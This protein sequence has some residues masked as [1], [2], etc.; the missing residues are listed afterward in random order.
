MVDRAHAAQARRSNSGIVLAAKSPVDVGESALLARAASFS[1]CRSLADLT[2]DKLREISGREGLDF[3]TSL[4]YDRVKRSE[5]HAAFIDRIDQWQTSD[6][7]IGAGNVVVGVIPAAFYKET[8]NSGADGKLI[9]EEGRHLGLQSKL[10]PLSSTGTLAE[11]SKIIF[12]WLANHQGNEIILVSLCKGSADVKFAL[13]SPGAQEK[14][15]D[16]S[17][18]VNICGT[19]N[20]SP[21]AEWLLAAKPRYF[22][23]WVCC[24]C[25]GYGM[26]FLREVAPSRQGPLTQPLKLPSSIRLI[27]V[28]GFP[29][30][31]HLTNQ[32][33]RICYERV[34]PQGP[35]DGGVLLADACQL[36]GVIYPVWGADHY[37]R[38][39]S[40]A[41]QIIGAIL[42]SLMADSN[43]AAPGSANE[44]PANG[45]TAQTFSESRH[46]NNTKG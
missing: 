23:T 19:L 15:R 38:P 14:F 12:D 5:Q 21:V 35:N 4:L 37:L 29:L 10:I 9:L 11:N 45:Q 13:N 30:R 6:R 20:G 27:N 25:R 43:R 46:A 33:I 34:S 40:R 22:L 36:P 18:W 3:A 1:E 7:K 2:A 31:H 28:V 39:E 24:K 26:D 8:P 17:V 42:E 32:F 41:R 44:T 16:V